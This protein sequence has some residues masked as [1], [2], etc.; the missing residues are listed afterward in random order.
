MQIAELCLRLMEAATP[1]TTSD[2]MS[3]SDWANKLSTLPETNKLTVRLHLLSLMFEVSRLIAVVTLYSMKSPDSTDC[4]I[5]Y[6]QL[7]EQQMF[8]NIFIKLVQIHVEPF[9]DAKKFYVKTVSSVNLA[10][11]KERLLLFRFV[12]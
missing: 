8:L 10:Y 12:V 6:S 1:L 11:R 3:V 9:L 7:E 4:Q 2:T 5:S